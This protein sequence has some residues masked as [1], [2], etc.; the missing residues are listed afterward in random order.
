MTNET[1]HT[2]G[3]WK[4]I[5][6]ARNPLYTKHA[7]PHAVDSTDAY[8]GTMH[9]V[10]YIAGSAHDSDFVADVITDIRPEGEANARLIAAAPELLEACKELELRTRD[11]IAGSLVVF[12]TALLPQVRAAIAKAT[13]EK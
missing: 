8:A 10:W 11:F 13:G 9:H 7:D 4:L 12:P 5:D 1:K 3:P 2:P 6:E